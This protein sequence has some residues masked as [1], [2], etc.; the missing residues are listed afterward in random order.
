MNSYL[1]VAARS[2]VLSRAQVQEVLQELRQFHPHIEFDTNW[3][4]TT[5]DRDLNTSLRTLEKTDFFTKEID[6][7]LLSGKCRLAIHS[8]KD[9]PEPLPQGLIVVALTQG[10]D[11]SDV[12]VLRDGDTLFPA[13]KIGTSSARREQNILA[14]RSDLICVDIRGTILQRLALLDTGIVDGVVMAEAALIR[15]NLTQRNRIPLPGERAA[16]QGQL[17]IVALETDVEMKNLF[18]CLDVRPKTILY[19]GT[20]PSHFQRRPQDRVLHY[21]VIKIV[22]RPI[23]E[24][25]FDNRFTHVIF[26]SKNAVKIFCSYFSNVSQTLI[27]IGTVTAQHLIA[28]GLTP[29]IIAEEETQEGLV[30]ILSQ[31]DWQGAHV[32]FPRS[33]LSRPVLSQF[34]TERNIRFETCDLYDTVTYHLEPKPDLSAVDEIVFTS[35]STVRAFIEIFGKLPKHKT[36][37]AIGPITKL[38]LL[39]AKEIG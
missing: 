30:K 7:L 32:F 11:P 23:H 24:V 29:H 3:V 34:F 18:H 31:L 2:S 8:A 15:L 38:T 39:N 13:A 27:A 10:L 9:L 4:E 6:A 14:L 28:E 5:G 22:P 19:I 1:K 36:L 16:L 21:P 33:A 37:Q 35:P 26:T 20:D 12:I 17:A 25:H